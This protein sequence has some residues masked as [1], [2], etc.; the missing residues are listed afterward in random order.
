MDWCPLPSSS[1]GV[2]RL[3]LP[4]CGYIEPEAIT[5][6]GSMIDRP[7]VVGHRPVP[8]PG[9]YRPLPNHGV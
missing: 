4:G 9:V 5:C 7:A 8:E 6:S 3:S 1:R 2:Q